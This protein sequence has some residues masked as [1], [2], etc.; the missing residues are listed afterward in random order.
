MLICRASIFTGNTSVQIFCPFLL[1]WELLVSF[2]NCILFLYFLLCKS[3]SIFVS[4]PSTLLLEC[5]QSIS[6]NLKSQVIAILL[7]GLASLFH[8]YLHGPCWDLMLYILYICRPL[9][10]NIIFCNDWNILC[11]WTLLYYLIWKMNSLRLY[12]SLPLFCLH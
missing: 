2:E 1:V 3:S 6:N 9:L 11:I 5:L 7:F 10:S 4:C 12:L 8:K